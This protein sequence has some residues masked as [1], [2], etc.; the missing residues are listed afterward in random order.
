[1]TLLLNSLAVAGL[2][3]ALA[4]VFGVAAAVALGGLPARGRPAGWAAA[5]ACLAMPPFLTANAWLELTQGWRTALPWE[6]AHGLSLP[7]VALL[8]ALLTWPAV[9]LAVQGAWTVLEPE[10]LEALPALRGRALLRHLLLPAAAPGLRLGAAVAAWLALANFTVP[11]LF[12]VRV[13]TEVVWVRFNTQWDTW[14]ALAA[15]WPLIALPLALVAW[16][17]RPAVAWPQRQGPVPPALWRARL[18]GWFTGAA[19]VSAGVLALSAGVPLWRLL[20]AERTWGELPGAWAAGRTAVLNSVTYAA[21]AAAL[22]LGAALAAAGWGRARVRGPRLAWLPLLVPGIFLGIAAVNVANRPAL[23]WLYGTPALVVAVLALRYLA[24]VWAAVAHALRAADPDLPAAARLHGAGWW[25]RA[26]HAHGPRVRPAAL[27]AA[28]LAY[29]LCLWDVESVLLILPPGGETLATRVFN[30][31]HYGHAS[32]VNALCLLL[33]A[34]A[35]TPALLVALAGFR[36]WEGG[37]S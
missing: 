24:P 16:W 29:G 13:F 11:V 7:L 15:G 20:L 25:W 5:A 1:M 36:R 4:A 23:G 3:A 10:Q 22:A 12:Q 30:L 35:V 8:L 28:Y 6:L 14:G 27:A 32:Q 21:L 19:A 26:R 31:L 34:L 9:T 37:G 2:A 17:P 33:L 18:G